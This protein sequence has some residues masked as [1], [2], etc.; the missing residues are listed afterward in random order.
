MKYFLSFYK[1]DRLNSILKSGQVQ[2]C[3][4]LTYRCNLK[5]PYCAAQL[6]GKGIPNVKEKTFEE[7]KEYIL[8]FPVKVKEICFSGGEPTLYEDL[9]K[10]ANW[11]LDTGR[12]VVLT[13]NLWK[14]QRIFE[15]QQSRKFIITASYHKVDDP[16]RF[17]KAY[18]Q[19]AEDYQIKVREYEH[20]ILP[21]S[22]LEVLNDNLDKP[23][24]TNK[25]FVVSPDAK[26]YVTCKEYY[27]ERAK[28]V[29]EK[30][31]NK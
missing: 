27:I 5:C 13:T 8:S 24:Y 7:W 4:D 14:Y 9:P 22:D 3:I 21:Y 29:N 19:L 18:R 26:I 31:Q 12:G 11:L 2:L 15:I 16:I 1:I 10:L 23:V 30:G 17:D 20:K 6:G 25:R 28:G